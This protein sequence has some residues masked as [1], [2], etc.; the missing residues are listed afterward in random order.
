VAPFQVA[1][2]ET[3]R[4]DVE[5]ERLRKILVRDLPNRGPL[6]ADRRSNQR[7]MRRSVDLWMRS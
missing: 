7:R 5:A 3:G 4:A 2:R 1:A 6:L